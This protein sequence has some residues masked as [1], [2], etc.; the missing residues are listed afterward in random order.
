TDSS[1]G[2]NRNRA[3]DFNVFAPELFNSITVRKTASA[4]TEEGSLGATVDLQTGRPF[5]YA[6]ANLV[7]SGQY[8]YNDLSQ[9]WDP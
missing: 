9:E 8:G 7:L 4:E 1:G 6:G 2:A 5:D 3:F